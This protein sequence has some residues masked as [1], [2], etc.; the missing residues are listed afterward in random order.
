MKTEDIFLEAVERPTPS[1]RADFLARACGDDPALRDRIEGLIASHEQAGTFLEGALFDPSASAGAPLVEGPGTRIGPYELVKAI[2]EGGMGTVYLAEQARPVRRRVALKVIKPGMDSR[3]VI[4]RFEAERQALAMMDHPNIARVLDAGTTE[5][6]LP[7]F[8]M[9]LVDGIPITDYCD[10]ARLSVAERLELFGSVCRAVQHAHQKGV[11]HRDLKPSNVLVTL[12]DGAAVP[13][14]I[15]FGVA[16][17]IGDPLIEGTLLTG[18][19]QIVGTP[20][21]MSP[22][23]AGISGMDVDTRSDV[24]SLGVLLYELL[25]GTTPIDRESFRKAA[26]DEIR[27]VVREQ[28]PPTPSNRLSTLGETLLAVSGNRQ[29][30]PRRLG[31]T[32]RGELDWVV[33]KALE[34]D[35]GRRYESAGDFAA[36][37]SR[38]L[39]DRPVEARRPSRAYLLRKFVRRNRGRVAA[40]GLIV[41]LGMALAVA[42]GWQ[43]AERAA[44][45]AE[46]AGAV[47]QAMDVADRWAR[48]AKW[49]EAMAAT[50]QAEAI[51]GTVGGDEALRRRCR[52]LRNDLAMVL[53]LDEIRL[54]MSAVKDN[55]FDSALGDRLYAEAFRAYGIDPATS[56]PEDVASR[57]PIGPVRDELVAALDDW[58]RVRRLAHGSKPGDWMP[59]L[60]L[61]RASDPDPW[62]DGVRAAWMRDD[63]QALALSA[64][65]APL[66]RLHPCSV[67]LLQGSLDPEPAV[68]LLRDA[69]QHHPGD[70]WL[71]EELGRRLIVVQPPRADEAQGYLRAAVAL[72]PE[73]PGATLNLGYSLKL[74]GRDAEAVP[75]YERV[76][77]LK[78]DYV[79]AY[80]NL[81]FSLLEVGRVEAAVLANREAIR[82]EPQSTLGQNQLGRAL[83]A[84]GNLRHEVG[85]SDEAIASFRE[86]IDLLPDDMEAHRDLG[87]TFWDVGR[88][89]EALAASRRA[90]ELGCEEPPWLYPARHW[91][92]ACEALS[93]M[94]APTKVAERNRAMGNFLSSLTRYPCT[95]SFLNLLST[96]NLSMRRRLIMLAL[97]ASTLPASA[98]AQKPPRYTFTSF[99]VPGAIYTRG[100]D[101][102][103]NGTIIGYFNDAAGAPHGYLYDG[104]VFTQIDEPDAT[105]GTLA[106]A[107]NDAGTIVGR[108]DAP[109]GGDAHGFVLSGGSFTPFD[110]PGATF[111]AAR[112]I[113]PAGDVVGYY[114][115]V[116]GVSHGF[117]LSGGQFTWVDY[118]GTNFTALSGMN[119]FG[120]IVGHYLD[121]AGSRRGFLLSGG[122]FSSVNYPKATYTQPS[123]IN[124]SGQIVGHYQAADG[125]VHGFLLSNGIY[126]TINYPN[127][128]LTRLHGITDLGNI[129]GEWQD[130]AGRTHGFYAV[131][132]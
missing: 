68:T 124:S 119:K 5:A 24:Y 130:S 16:K 86:A 89:G 19:Q 46:T 112:G 60:A 102:N 93:G 109:L 28:D 94:K 106:G 69:L 121:A 20:L 111:T 115:D 33:M 107:I 122:Q 30:D 42:V 32:L 55:A 43:A 108:F 40:L 34:K 21:Y 12:V 123:R 120:R 126:T 58:A 103:N 92:E 47:A 64:A 75:V 99:D 104:G 85:A 80:T 82:L 88:F 36:D 67:L 4:A 50:Q 77:R 83:V 66:D 61:A 114:V 7:Y 117:V 125:S 76:I 79:V 6:G 71:N 31:H 51:L 100:G 116:A 95:V 23:Q 27:R 53:R 56:R 44:R 84:L 25:T 41:G 118:P 18:V 110:V 81:G 73:S 52:T 49:P 39:A 13:K 2:G 59:L 22:E 127:A 72:R 128:V 48:L 105:A 45:R 29:S 78:P 14:V 57:L 8:V 129:V 37:L 3:Q 1:E 38:Y 90:Q 65:S 9:D 96:R 132:R 98:Y 11:I 54:E 15:D 35:R 87:H 91:V 26:D 113:S 97:A 70:F 101:I 131:K 63:R 62:R 74:A 17:A 10:R